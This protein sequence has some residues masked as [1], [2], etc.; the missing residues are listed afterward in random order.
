MEVLYVVN[1]RGKLLF[2]FLSIFFWPFG[3]IDRTAEDMTGNKLREEG[4]V[5]SRKGTEAGS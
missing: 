3:F 1:V 4:G 5:I 2:F